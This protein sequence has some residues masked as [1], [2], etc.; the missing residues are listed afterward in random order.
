MPDVLFA[1]EQLAVLSTKNGTRRY[2]TTMGDENWPSMQPLAAAQGICRHSAEFSVL[3]TAL[4]VMIPG[5]ATM[6]SLVESC[7]LLNL[8]VLCLRSGCSPL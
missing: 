4:F 2:S 8:Y 3:R 5:A 1:M 7:L 6:F